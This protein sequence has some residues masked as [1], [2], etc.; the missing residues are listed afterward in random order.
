[1]IER[2]NFFDIYGYLLPGGLLVTLLW[3]PF[4]VALEAWPS[5]EWSSA[6]L[7]LL[8]AYVAG[9]F[10]RIVG[11]TTFVSKFKDGAGR[12][13]HPSDMVFD[14]DAEKRLPASCRLWDAKKDIADQ[15]KQEFG[16][17]VGAGQP[18]LGK[19]RI[20][21]VKAFAKCR[22]YIIH[23]DAAAYSEQQQGMYE[24]LRGVAAAAALAFALYVGIIS[25][26][27]WGVAFPVPLVWLVIGL[28]AIGVVALIAAIC[29]YRVKDDDGKARQ[30]L[31]WLFVSACVV[32]GVAIGVMYRSETTRTLATM[33]KELWTIGVLAALCCVS[34][35][36]FH[37]ASRGFAASFAAAVYRE[38][39]AIASTAAVVAPPP[40]PPHAGGPA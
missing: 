15:I 18:G 11:T 14:E 29:S 8:V 6:V 4:G 35:P 10:L 37:A 34:I 16:I 31:F 1:M 9:H 23:K 5:A 20:A 33:G 30:W 3:L 32:G 7:A 40:P 27:L 28:C 39:S 36:M 22:S 26:L 17:D 24:F 38:F 12:W 25:G 2:L 19:L 13:R 21:R